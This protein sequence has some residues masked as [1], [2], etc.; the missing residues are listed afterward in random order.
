MVNHDASA[1]TPKRHPGVRVAL[2]AVALG[3][4]A[5][6]LWYDVELMAWRYAWLPEGPRGFF[7]EVNV[8]FRDF[9]QTVCVAV[10][11][12]I[13]GVS[14]ARRARVVPGILMSVLLSVGVMNTGKYVVARHRP[15]AAV[16]EVVK[17]EAAR[18]AAITE[19]EA[20]RRV[21]VRDTWLG[22]RPELRS[23]AMR[24]FPSGHSASAFAFGLSLAC[25]YPRLR[26]LFWTL[27]V[28]CAA[29]RFLDAVHW[30]GDCYAGALIGYISARVGVKI[31]RSARTS[32]P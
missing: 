25:F 32:P 5:G 20:I 28:G 13:V 15:Y 19:A 9:G 3:G 1:P 8:S 4:L 17:A 16:G 18:G 12:I 22:I 31:G 7:K 6:A 10:G 23:N 24:S 2:W 30:A 26:W 29:S 21:S 11:L 27:A 14:D